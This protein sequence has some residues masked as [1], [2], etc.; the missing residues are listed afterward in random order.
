MDKPT[1]IGDA[2]LYLGDCLEIMP[3]LDKVDAVV[4]DPP[5][6]VTPTS[7]THYEKPGMIKGGWMGNEYPVNHGKMFEISAFNEWMP[8]VFQAANVNADAYIMSNDKNVSEMQRQ[9]VK[10]GWKFHNLLVWQKP[11]GIPNRW[12]FK[13]CEFTLYLW[14][15]AAVTINNPASTQTYRATHTS[16][17]THPSEKPVKLMMHYVGNSTNDAR[18]VVL[19]PFMGSGTTG[20]ACAKLGR[21]FVG[22]EIEPKYFDIAC[23][24]IED[25]YKKP[26]LFIEPPAKLTQSEIFEQGHELAIAAKDGDE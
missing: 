14:K 18:P 20:V 5:Y 21:K 11:T 17:R 10:A 9:A 4:T 7:K 19:D 24:R 23:K 12:Y 8:A 26:D 1:I 25:A 6:E 15:G 13:D 16:A 22:I 3:T 2:T